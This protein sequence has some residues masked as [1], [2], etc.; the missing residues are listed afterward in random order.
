MATFC[1]VPENHSAFRDPGAVPGETWNT[2]N[3]FAVLK[4]QRRDYQTHIGTSL[5]PPPANLLLLRALPL[6]RN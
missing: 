5:R 4:R 2:T 6:D 1:G 3:A